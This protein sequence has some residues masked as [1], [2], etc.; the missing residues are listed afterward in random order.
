MG[1]FVC[2]YSFSFSIEICEDGQES[3]ESGE[4]KRHNPDKVMTTQILFF[5]SFLSLFKLIV[6]TPPLLANAS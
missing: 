1:L 4:I 3:D 2:V 5:F 6:F